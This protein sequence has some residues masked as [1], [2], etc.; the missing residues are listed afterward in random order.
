MYEAKCPGCG[1][2]VVAELKGPCLP[3]IKYDATCPKCGMYFFGNLI[4][5]SPP[6]PKSQVED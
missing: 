3:G 1:S 2:M 5:L 6:P 4:P